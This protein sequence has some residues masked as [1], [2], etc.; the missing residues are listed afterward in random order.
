MAD[1][2][3]GGNALMDLEPKPAPKRVLGFGELPPKPEPVV[4][5]S[6]TPV[7]QSTKLDDQLTAPRVVKESSPLVNQSTSQPVNQPDESLFP[8][9]V[10]RRLKG[11][12][13]PA[14]KLD[15]YEAWHFQRRHIFKDFQDAVEYAMDW[16]TSQPDD[17][18]TSRPVNQTTTLINKEL[19]NLLNINDEKTRRL[20]ARYTEVTGRTVKAKD[21]EAYSEIAH[22][23]ESAIERGIIDAPRR[24]REAGH[25]INGFRYCIFSILDAAR[26]APA[27][28]AAAPTVCDLCTETP[29]FVWGDPDDRSKGMKPCPHREGK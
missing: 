23:D 9:R 4:D 5:W 10:E 6:T 20:M 21:L 25:T 8:S 13:F 3:K 18:L 24:A 14:K 11:I 2:F 28:A 15:A 26:A 22:L 1:K 7:N 19:N 29:G 16:L 27:P 12:R 17:Q